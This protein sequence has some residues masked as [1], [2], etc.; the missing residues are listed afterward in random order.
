MRVKITTPAAPLFGIH[1]LREHVRVDAIDGSHPDDALLLRQSEA[2]RA[3]AEHYAG[4]AIGEQSW[5][6][7]ADGWAALFALPL[8]GGDIAS[9]AAVEGRDPTTGAWTL[10]APTAYYLDEYA[11]PMQLR[12]APG[13]ALPAVFK[14]SNSVRVRYI[15]GKPVPADILAAILIVVGELYLNRETS[16]SIQ[17]YDVPLSAMHLLDPHRLEIGV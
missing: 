7:A 13:A 9:V 5:E 14:V 2:G 8:P 6:V 12:Q 10:L 15:I 16:S 1:L 3:W 17:L 11:V 4:R